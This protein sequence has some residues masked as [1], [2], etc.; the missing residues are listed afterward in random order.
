M[1]ICTCMRFENG[2]HFPVDRVVQGTIT[3][4]LGAAGRV[5]L[6]GPGL[7]RPGPLFKPLSRRRAVRSNQMISATEAPEVG[8]AFLRHALRI[9]AREHG[10]VE[11]GLPTLVGE[12]LDF[13]KSS[14]EI[15]RRRMGF[16][17]HRA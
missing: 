14:L 12:V 7:R 1:Q 10:V 4:I 6:L 11:S 5:N 9:W 17:P 15:E 16:D 2:H 8:N 13:A 3:D